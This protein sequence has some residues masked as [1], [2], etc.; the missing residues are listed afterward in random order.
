MLMITTTTTHTTEA[1]LAATVQ[2][3]SK[4]ATGLRRSAF[5]PAFAR[6]PAR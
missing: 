3:N 1:A 6:R 5:D 4:P 2:L